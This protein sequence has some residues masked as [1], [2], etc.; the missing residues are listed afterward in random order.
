MTITLSTNSHDLRYSSFAM[1]LTRAAKVPVSVLFSSRKNNS[2]ATVGIEGVFFY[3]GRMGH[4][5]LPKAAR[6]VHLQV[7]ARSK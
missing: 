6:D 2:T 4:V 1:V 7:P 3:Y 5:F